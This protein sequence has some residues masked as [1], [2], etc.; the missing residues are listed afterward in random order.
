MS[1]KE[2]VL[3]IGKKLDN[4]SKSGAQE[5]AQ[6]MDLLNA[7]KKQRMTLDVLQKTHIGMTVN[8]F[9]KSTT[10]EEVISLAK[11]LIK[12]WKKLLPADG[13]PS[14][15]SKSGEGSS[16]EKMDDKEDGD[17]SGDESVSKNAPSLPPRVEMTSNSVRNKCREMLATALKVSGPEGSDPPPSDAA[18]AED[19][20][21]AIEDCIYD[22]EGDTNMRYKN[23][24]RSRYANLK[25]PKNVSLRENVLT[26]RITPDQIAIMT[27]EEMANEDLKALRKKFTKEAIDDHQM[28][29]SEGTKTDLLKCNKCRKRNVT[30]N[31]MQT[32]SADEP[33]TT[34]CFCNECG[35]RWKFC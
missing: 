11:S 27:P 9:R 18:S 17:G 15:D 19:V 1:C 25:D 6:S 7:L 24:I 34:F 14:K 3:R 26:G 32:R 10:N 35:N 29:K 28:A 4:L 2:E 30:Y 16:K 13:T 22:K 5:H 21:A 23:K 20:A 8:S 31:Q 33:M 12:S